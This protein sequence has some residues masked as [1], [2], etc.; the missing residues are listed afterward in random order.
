MASLDVEG[1]GQLGA[2]GGSKV[3]AWAFNSTLNYRATP[4]LGFF[5]VVNAASGG[6]SGKTSRLFDQLYPTGHG[7]YGLMDLNSWRN[8]QQFG[9][10]ARYKIRPDLEVIGNYFGTA[11]RDPSDAWYTSSGAASKF[12][13]STGKAGREVGNEF[14]L[15]LHWDVRKDTSIYGGFGVFL[16]GRFVRTL[17]PG[18]TDQVFG[19]VQ[20]S[21]KF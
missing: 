8:L 18:A 2:R 19:Y 7:I 10:G 16:P 4:K 13:D 1:V 21:Y 9:L 14:D 11:L 3:E 17:S 12:V 6:A 20:V 15:D 5:A